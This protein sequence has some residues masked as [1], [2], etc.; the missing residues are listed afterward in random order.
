MSKRLFVAL[1]I[2][3]I[4]LQ[5]LSEYPAKQGQLSFLKWEPSEH[6]HTTVLFLSEV[7]DE[8]VP[9][10]EDALSDIA[11]IQ[12][13]FVLEVEKIIYAPEWQ[14]PS[15]V[16]ARLKNHKQFTLLVSRVKEELY[17]ILGDTD[18][19]EVIPHI[20]L[21]RFNKKEATPKVLPNLTQIERGVGSMP[22]TKMTLMESKLPTAHK[23]ES[24][25]TYKVLKEFSLKK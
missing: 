5:L 6:L 11:A 20:T 2:E 3:G 12:Q 17:Y 8:L 7:K 21:A 15:M 22:V 10:I 19:K 24:G 9:E 18:S 4:L 13:A 16:W 14:R 23:S 25:P 1:P